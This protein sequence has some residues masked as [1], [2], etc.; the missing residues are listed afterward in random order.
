MALE[1]TLSLD[2][3]LDPEGLLRACEQA[4]GL[5][6]KPRIPGDIVERNAP[7][8]FLTGAFAAPMEREVLEDE[9]GIRPRVTVTFRLDKEV[10]HAARLR[11][12]RATADLLTRIPGDA[13]LVFNGDFV[14]LVR[15][16]GRVL[17]NA[18]DDLFDPDELAALD[19]PYERA[20]LAGL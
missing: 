9:L 13:A 20:H 16:D 12:L 19:L 11:M 17:V 7:G 8:M 1:Y 15:R 14:L 6:P 10:R 3:A 5:S 2:S 4:L 18:S